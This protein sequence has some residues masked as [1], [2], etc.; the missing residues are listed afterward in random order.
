[1]TDT[2]IARRAFLGLGFAAG[3]TAALSACSASNS[4][5]ALVEPTGAAVRAA[6]RARHADGVT[7]AIELT[8]APEKIDLAG[9]MASTWSFGS[10]PASTIRINAG[11]TLRATLI[12]RLPAPTSVHWHGVALRNDMDGVPPV[13]QAAVQPGSRFTYDFV[14][15]NPGT[16]W[17]HPHVGV[18]L[19]R[20]LYGALVVQDPQEPLRYDAE[21]VVVLDDWL[22]TTPDAVLGQLS[23]GMSSMGGMGSMNG[24]SGMMHDG[25]VLMGASSKLLGGDA[26]DVYYPRYLINGRPVEDPE[27]FRAKPGDRVRI[28]LINAGGDTAFRVALGA[29]TMTV[30]H[31]DGYPVEPAQVDSLLIGMGERYDVLVTVGAGVFP[32]VAAAEGKQDSGFALLRTTGGSAPKRPKTLPELD[33]RVGSAGILAASAAVALPAKRAD[34]TVRFVVTGGMKKYDWMINGRAFNEKNPLAGAAEG[35]QGER[36][37]LEFTNKTTMWHPMHLHGHTYQHAGG[38]PRKDTSIVLPGQT[39]TAEFDA[40]NPGRW[41]VHCHNI[42]HQESGMMSVLAYRA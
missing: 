15:E 33:K 4:S 19:D 28:R 22:D 35:R 8:A 39:V 12:N 34:R 25:N 26:G 31:T 7:R 21:W 10:V 9:K 32:L 6:E 1:M 14:A 13:T 27:T 3:A 17:F 18:Q 24:M 36:V 41:V 37:R 5:P 11:D 30:T 2:P 16:Y 42:Y 38:G 40:D 23:K 20:G 29:H